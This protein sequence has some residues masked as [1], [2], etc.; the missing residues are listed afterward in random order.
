MELEKR[1]KDL[2]VVMVSHIFATGAFLDL[3]EFLKTK[4]NA[5]LFIGHPFS[6]RKEVNSFYRFYSQEKLIKTHRAFPWRLPEI[7]MYIKDFLYTFKWVLFWPNKFDYYFAADNYDGFL[8]LIFKKIGKVE[9]VVF[10][11]IDYV[12]NRFKNPLLNRLYHYFDAQCLKHCKIVWNISPNMVAAREKYNK[13]RRE[14]CV[15]QIVV[16][17]GIWYNRI[18]KPPLA[19]RNRY[20]IVFLGHLVERQGLDLVIRAL[21]K[22][23]KKIPKVSL[24]IIGT[25]SFEKNLKNIVRERKLNKYVTFTGYIEKDTDIERKIAESGIAVAMYKPTSD[26]LTYFADPGKIKNYLSAGLPIVLTDVPPIARDV[27]EKK[28]AFIAKYEEED[29][30]EKV[31]CLLDDKKRLKE[32][33]K[34][35]IEYAS[36][37]DWNIIYLEALE[38]TIH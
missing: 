25:G 7:F 26:N 35:A 29:F 3:E 32:Y 5:L 8:G 38:K 34:N 11:T 23:I 27:Q 21:P 36:R 13:L 4:V 12:P 2:D 30:S 33:S 24:L 9:N 15:S 19:K 20:R 6:F 1:L 37:F 16:P 17:Q 18:P 14:K 28:C 10:Y 31:I 22:I